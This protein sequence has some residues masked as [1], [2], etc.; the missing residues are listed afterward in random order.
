MIN[1]RDPAFSRVTSGLYQACLL[2]GLLFGLAVL[3]F[4]FILA[5]IFVVMLAFVVVVMAFVVGLMVMVLA[6]AM[7]MV[8]VLALFA[9]LFVMVIGTLLVM[10]SGGFRRRGLLRGGGDLLHIIPAVQLTLRGRLGHR[11]GGH[12]SQEKYGCGHSFHGFTLRVEIS[13]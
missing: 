11:G 7:V 10:L 5:R 1:H 4:A 6:F 12:C 2:L 13:G 3:G 8:V 9:A